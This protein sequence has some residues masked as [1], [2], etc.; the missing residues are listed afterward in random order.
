VGEGGGPDLRAISGG[1]S[2]KQPFPQD[3][4]AV[5]KAA[6]Y[7]DQGY[8]PIPIPPRTKAP[9]EG[10]NLRTHET[11]S[12]SLEQDFANPEANIGVRLGEVSKGLVDVDLDCEEV[13]K[14]G[15]R[16]L[17][18]TPMSFGR[19]SAPRSHA[20]YKCLDVKTEKFFDPRKSAEREHGTLVEIR[21]DGCQTVFPGSV[22]PSGEQVRFEGEPSAPTEVKGY[23]LHRRVRTL[24]SAALLGRYWPADRSRHYP[25]LALA[26]ALLEAGWEDQ[27]AE[28]FLRA[29]CA[30]AGDENPEK[31]KSTIA[32]TRAR[33][34]DGE[35]VM[36][37]A[38]LVET[39]G[40]DVVKAV[41]KWLN[42]RDD[43]V[44]VSGDLRKMA[45]AAEKAVAKE[46]GQD[47]SAKV[48]VRGN[49]LV[50]VERSAEQPHTPV[51]VKVPDAALQEIAASHMRWLKLTQKGEKHVLP[52]KEVI[53]ALVARAVWPQ[54]GL[55][56][57]ITECPILRPDG[58]VL[59]EPGLDTLTGTLY[60]PN[61]E[62]LRVPDE[63]T[64]AEQE[65][66][67]DLVADA[68]SDFPFQSPEHKSAAIAAALTPVARSAFEGPVPL[69]LFEAPDGGT[70]KDLC[71]RT[72]G[73]MGTRQQPASETF[74]EDVNEMR[75][76]ITSHAIEGSR[77]VL[78]GNVE[79]ELGGAPLEDAL[80]LEIY[81]DR[82]LGKNANWRGPLRTTF[83]ASQNNAT[84]G[85]TMARRICPVRLDAQHERPDRR[86]DFSRTKRELLSHVRDPIFVVS[87]L[88]LLRAYI[89]AGRPNMRVSTWGSYEEWSELV[90]GALKFAGLPD[91][92]DARDEL[93]ERADPRAEYTRQ[94]VTGF[95]WL[96]RT[97]GRLLTAK[98][99]VDL[100]DK[101]G[102]LIAEDEEARERI[103][104]LRNAALALLKADTLNQIQLG[105]LLRR[106][107]G[108]VRDGTVIVAA[109]SRNRST[110][111]GA[112]WRKNM[113]SD[114]AD[115]DL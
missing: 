81:S 109:G 98:Q 52:P 65:M 23:E 28:A 29:V 97:S 89:V 78:L 69:F 31:R 25:Q 41:R 24:A 82:I 112:K 47:F 102:D 110:L 88:I 80:T 96:I 63:P 115:M 108:K 18:K 8:V 4:P 107:E 3:G 70:G 17:P 73:I 38:K 93:T 46:G 76:R 54:L 92:G 64:K 6:W 14:V 9:G 106:N 21:S 27:E 51:F 111:W 85:V 5:E 10:W 114:M 61:A 60:L 44:Y 43:V 32:T 37:W 36:S 94:F 75:K 39:I 56:L 53:Q 57:Q 58:T 34:N 20:E 74:S 91:P 7:L 71:A 11:A 55:A 84:I 62:Y 77:I 99:A 40:D 83:Y 103:E 101:P 95:A 33:I 26:G 16:F 66:A 86:T 59:N 105:I 13:V 67:K 90:I 87:L 48:Y 35:P 1:K 30:I 72:C 42:I 100:M 104:S 79:G 113:W 45:T 15:G 68:F 49:S 2:K 50:R 22:H 19:K 12:A